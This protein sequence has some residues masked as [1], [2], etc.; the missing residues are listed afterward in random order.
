MSK[1]S[2]RNSLVS[3]AVALVV[4]VVAFLYVD[5]DRA[6]QAND[7]TDVPDTF[8]TRADTTS[9]WY[10]S[11]YEKSLLGVRADFRDPIF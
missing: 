3:C 10:A 7:E 4:I 2:K 8:V 9:A 5:R 6:V 1:K 11:N